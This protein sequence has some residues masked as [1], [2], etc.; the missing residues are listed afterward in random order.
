MR[1]ASRRLAVVLAIAALTAVFGP[2]R[3]ADLLTPSERSWLNAH[4]NTI[5]YAPCPNYPPYDFVGPGGSHSGLV[6]DQIAQIE[7]LLGVRFQLVQAPSWDALLAAARTHEVDLISSVTPTPE[8]E[9]YLS[10][11]PPLFKVETVIIVSAATPRPANVEALNGLTIGAGKGYIITS[12]F[13]REHPQIRLREFADDEAGL[14]ALA[15]GEIDGVLT[16]LGT[17]TWIIKQ[18]QLNNLRLGSGVLYRIPNCLATRSDWP[19]LRE[20]LSKA[21][22]AIPDRQNQAMRDRWIGRLDRPPLT[23]MEYLRWGLPIIGPAL[24]LLAL[25]LFWSWSLRRQVGRRTR[26]LAESERTYREIFTATSDALFVHEISGRPLDVNERACAMFGCT[27]ETLLSLPADALSLG[28]PPYSQAEAVAWVQLAAAAG[29]QVFEWHSRRRNGELFWS[30]IAL[31]ACTISGQPRVIACVRDIEERKRTEAELRQSQERLR[32]AEKL[33]SIGHLAGGIAHDFNNQIG[34]I[35]GF[36][37]ILQARN[38]DPGAARFIDGILQTAWRAADLTRQLLAFAR[39]GEFVAAPVNLHELIAEVVSLLSHSLD[40][41]IVIEQELAAPNPIICGDPTQLQNALLNL[42]INARDAM[43]DGGRLRF[44]TAREIISPESPAPDLPPGQY[45]MVTVSDTGIGMTPEVRR[46]LFE[47]FFTTKAPGK[48]TG[49]GL[50]ALYG[51]IKSHHG[52]IRV[53]SELG[54]GST[55]KLLLPLDQTSSG[56]EPA[57]APEPPAPPRLARILLIDDESVIRETTTATLCE[58]GHE[59]IAAKDGQHAIELYQTSWQT[60]DLIILDMIMPR[61]GGRE[62]FFGLRQINP[63]ANVI[64]ASGYCTNDEIQAILSEG[65]RAF[66]SKP[67]RRSKLLQTIAE[68]LEP[69]TPPGA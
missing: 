27:R 12:L 16:D 51:A 37:E 18:R 52:A 15:L 35:V 66:I 29:P 65:V 44:A 30:E 5:R 54:R 23:A 56:A 49:L 11:T 46:R 60:I 58:A 9:A 4:A 8:R 47:P 48:G 68:V 21:L 3:A 25:T 67:F 31:R 28:R 34:G 14:Q 53:E 19:Q 42:A 36:A 43:P 33:D 59:V 1:T 45:L 38:Q 57:A 69:A 13:R 40:K 22:A 7:S 61:L 2:A 6:A 41:R 50:A 62:T 17:A 64:I 55:F 26:E 20:I 24:S 63:Q 39:K 10:F 32:H